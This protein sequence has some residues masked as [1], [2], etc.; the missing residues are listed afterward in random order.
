MTDTTSTPTTTAF[1]PSRTPSRI[2]SRTPSRAGALYRCAGLPACLAAAFTLAASLAPSATAQDRTTTPAASQANPADVAEL[3]PDPRVIIGTL[4]NGLTYKV[5][6]HANPPGRI[7]VW[8]H[9]SSGSLNES[10]AQRGLAHYLEHLAFN[11]SENFPPGTV[12]EFFQSLGLR[13]GLHQNAFTTFDQTVYQLELPDNSVEKLDKALLFF[14]DVCGRLLLDP[15]EIEEERQV[16]M[17]EKASRKSAAQRI[18]EAVLKRM[19][20]GSIIGERLPIGVDE[21]ILN[22]QRD[23]FADYYNRFYTPSNTTVIAVGDADP[24]VMIDRIT[25]AFGTLP[26]RGPQPADMDPRVTAYADS[27]AVVATDPEMTRAI[28]TIQRVNPA[29]GPSTTV[30]DVRRDLVEL[31][32]TSAFNRRLSDKVTR[33]EVALL[34]GGASAGD[35]FRAMRVA[36]VRAAAEPARWRDALRDLIV[37]ARRATLHG[38]K[39]S[40]IALARTEL[41]AALEQGAKA[42]ATLPARAYLS[43]INNA[44]AEGEPIL[45]A[46]QI[47]ELARRLLTDVT[48]SEVHEAFRREMDFSVFMVAAQLPATLPDNAPIPTEQELLEVA[49]AALAADVAPMEERRVATSLMEKAPTAGAVAEATTHEATGVW[50]ALLDN[51][52]RVHHRAMDYRKDSATVTITLYGGEALETAANRGITAA[53]AFAFSEPATSS[54]ASSDIRDLMAGAKVQVGGGQSD[55]GLVLSISGDPADLERGFQLAHLLLTDPF[56]EPPG[57]ERWRVATLQALAARDRNPASVMGALSRE[58]NYPEGDPRFTRLTA[59]NVNAITRDAAQALLLDM[60]RTAPIE[61]A[62]VGDVDR[63]R[64]EE[65]TKTYL[66]SLPQRAPVTADLLKEPRTLPR[67]KAPRSDMGLVATQTPIAATRVAFYGPDSTNIDDVRAMQMASQI[68][69]TRMILRI[70]EELQLVYGI[71]ASSAPGTLYPG[72][73]TFSAG[74]TTQP[75]KTEQLRDEIIA[76]FAAFAKDGPTAEE[77]DV[78]KRQFA[79]TLDESMRDPAFWQARLANMT[80]SGAKL[81]DILATPKA[82]QELTPERITEVFRRYW[83]DGAPGVTMTMPLAEEVPVTPDA[84]DAAVAPAPAPAPA[85][86]AAPPAPA[87][88]NTPPSS[89]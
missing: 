34:G 64:I 15:R 68:L 7:A 47:D 63:A 13:F 85:G 6:R 57:L 48:A 45:S 14:A 40:E 79:N 78:A 74:S 69:S 70:R 22:A 59:D 29:R 16:I 1:N 27:F 49:K 81:D 10:D 44:V 76:A 2:H 52:V 11:G 38:F 71:S 84:P 18:N 53:A 12:I 30:A 24:Q 86:P 37:E 9:V 23:V 56:I 17:E 77:V 54:L 4:P 31:L 42:E 36:G 89:Q 3:T 21:V 72:F 26:D 58:L 61:V 67:A 50:S 19:A 87:T 46:T 28:V 73:G 83:G 65:L 82:M 75:G 62:V 35:Q 88:P 5:M 39:E 41:L 33:G 43:R 32:A 8:M 80:F 66:G 60:V 55:T 51:G 25:A 20:P